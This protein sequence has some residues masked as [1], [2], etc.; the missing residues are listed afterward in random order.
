M[1]DVKGIDDDGKGIEV[2]EFEEDGEGYESD[3]SDVSTFDDN[4][5]RHM[6]RFHGRFLSIN[7]VIYSRWHSIIDQRAMSKMNSSYSS[8]YSSSRSRS[9]SDVPSNLSP[10]SSP[11]SGIASRD[12]E[13]EEGIAAK[14]VESETLKPGGSEN[15]SGD[16]EEEMD[17]TNDGNNSSDDEE[18]P[19]E[20]ESEDLAASEVESNKSFSGS[21]LLS[22]SS[23]SDED[24]E[25]VYVLV[26]VRQRGWR[27]YFEVYE[28]LECK[29]YY[30]QVPEETSR[31]MTA[32]FTRLD[33]LKR[34][35][36]IGVNV[37]GMSMRDGKLPDTSIVTFQQEVC[38]FDLV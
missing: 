33:K 9:S 14:S 16:S 19:S 31:S 27:L 37:G 22:G 23:E 36:I 3:V 13:A 10:R 17:D 1:S 32:E 18:P 30:P 28:P 34:N 35:T 2:V 15:K 20:A 4:R 38:S 11:A 8:S 5:H 25:N 21:S 6:L 26:T 7:R 12:G 24:P 29:Y